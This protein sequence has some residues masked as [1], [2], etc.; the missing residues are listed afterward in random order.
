[1]HVY[2]DLKGKISHR[3]LIASFRSKTKNSSFFL[4][5]SKKNL[6]IVAS[7]RPT[8]STYPSSQSSK[9]TSIKIR[10]DLKESKEEVPKLVDPFVK[11]ILSR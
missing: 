2:D 7:I 8:I 10:L 3:I 9:S 4:F 1:M 6:E 11:P 5:L